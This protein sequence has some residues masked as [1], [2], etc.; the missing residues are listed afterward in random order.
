[1][2]HQ[3][4]IHSVPSVSI[5]QQK[6]PWIGLSR[7]ESFFTDAETKQLLGKV[8]DYV[9]AGANVNISGAAGLGKTSLAL[10]AAEEV[11]RPVAFMS[12]NQWLAASDFIGR[13]VGQTEK[14]IVDKYVQSV[15]RTEAE[16]RPDWRTAILGVAMQRGYTLV[17]DEF[18]RASPEANSI[19]LS[20][21][22]EG[23]LVSTD[24][25]SGKSYIR[26]HEDFRIIFTSNPLD[27]AGVMA[28]PDALLDRLLTIK[29][30]PPSVSKLAGIVAMRTGL[31]KKTAKRV[32]SAVMNVG[33]NSEAQQSHLRSA[34][35][36]GRIAAHRIRTRRL[37][38]DGLAE[39]FCD[40]LS[41]RGL[42]LAREQ[43]K[44]LLQT[45]AKKEALE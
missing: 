11:G 21:I 8:T 6:T 42:N 24:R 7:K 3:Q 34:I 15:R 26:A 33:Q 2:S 31:D 38:D 16:V 5:S 14:T 12:G 28:A 18:T 17:Y 13:E 36:V 30:Q 9:R 32:S 35:L 19:L 44:E 43:A 27:Y 45:T 22:E 41:G 39:I 10:R 1:M 23:V 40:V 29:L 4:S 37:T 20:V 25:A